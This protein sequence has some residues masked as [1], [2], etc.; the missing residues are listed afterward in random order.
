MFVGIGL[1]LG[2]AVGQPA[3]PQRRLALNEPPASSDGTTITSAA[4]DAITFA[5]SGSARKV[6]AWPVTVFAGDVIRFEITVTR[7]TY[8]RFDDAPDLNAPGIVDI[9]SGA[10]LAPGSHSV[11]YIVAEAAAARGYFG[12]V[13]ANGATAGN[14]EVRNFY[15][16]SAAS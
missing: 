4:V 13:H 15:M 12:F 14:A 1:G 7:T 5:T 8:I 16:G 2:L 10:G 9:V 6:L 11:E 3:R